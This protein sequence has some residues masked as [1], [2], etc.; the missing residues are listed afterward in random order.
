MRQLI[1][2]GPPN[3]FRREMRE[4]R[5]GIGRESETSSGEQEF[6]HSLN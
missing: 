1:F 3:L 2:I 4:Q 5:R 6:S